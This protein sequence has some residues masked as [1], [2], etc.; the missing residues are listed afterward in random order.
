MINISTVENI[1]LDLSKALKVITFYP[2]GHP[3]LNKVLDKVAKDISALCKNDKIEIEITKD[4]F[5][6]Q[7]SKVNLTNPVMRELLQTLFLRRVNKIIF[8][9]KVS[10]EELYDFI[11]LLTLDMNAIFSAGGLENIMETRNIENIALS[12]R[13]FAKHM[14]LKLK[15][16]IE[17]STKQNSEKP[18]FS[19]DDLNIDI[20][21]QSLPSLQGVKKSEET[22]EELWER[23]KKAL[24][25]IKKNQ[26]IGLYLENI[27]DVDTIVNKNKDNDN[28]M[29]DIFYTYAF[30]A[31]DNS[32]IFGFRKEAETFVK[33]KLTNELINRLLDIMLL[34]QNNETII[35]KIHTIFLV[36]G[37][38]AI[39]TILNKLTSSND[40]KERRFIINLVTK[41]GQQAF[42]RVIYFLDDERWYVVRNMLTILGFAGQEKYLN[43][44]SKLMDHPDMRVRKE[45]VKT[46]SRIPGKDSLRYLREMLKKEGD[47]VKQLVIFSLGILK[48]E[49]S[50]PDIINELNQNNNLTIKREALLAIGRI[51]NNTAFNIL[52]DFATRRTFFNKATNKILRLNAIDSLSEIKGEETKKVLEKLTGDS[53]TEVREKAFDALQ[54]IR[55]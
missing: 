29:M 6:V 26:D 45:L 42:E 30:D 2:E 53:D 41:L 49:S 14:E 36:S 18:I 23:I 9:C 17:A 46:F 38:Y 12:E 48:D 43:E 28:L 19:L 11:N 7:N 10:G 3:T 24:V 15:K 25:D 40:I 51:G 4:H 16:G 21:T 13:Q 50:L 34:N 39:D 55:T 8:T 1:L 20:S 52:K 37:V 47:E 35:N 22:D 44:I 32:L 31:S 27:K 33:N 5:T 54:K